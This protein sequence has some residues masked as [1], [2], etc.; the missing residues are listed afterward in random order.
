M[1][2]FCWFDCNLIEFGKIQYLAAMRTYF[3]PDKIFFGKRLVQ[4]NISQQVPL[5][6]ISRFVSRK[7]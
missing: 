5:N 2:V 4:D 3:H 7:S 1:V 6:P